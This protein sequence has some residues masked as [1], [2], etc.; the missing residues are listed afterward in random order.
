MMPE[1]CP[2]ERSAAQAGSGGRWNDELAAHLEGC[3]PCRESSRVA[4]WMAALAEGLD[5]RLPPLPDPRLVWLQARILGRSRHSDRALLPIRIAGALAAI[6]SGGV[7]AS[8]PG[9]GWNLNWEWLTNAMTALPELPDLLPPIPLT[10]LWIPAAIVAGCLL[11][12]TWNE[13]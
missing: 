10:A 5:S 2:Q 7:L 13:A 12:F 9:V 8:L 3:V 6:G 4:R 11:L 1:S